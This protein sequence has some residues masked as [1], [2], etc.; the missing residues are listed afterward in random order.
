MTNEQLAILIR[1]YA[2]RLDEH[3][4][5]L[6]DELPESNERHLKWVRK[7]E[8]PAHPASTVVIFASISGASDELEQK[9]IGDFIC[10]DGLHQFS[11]EL[12][13]QVDELSAAKQLATLKAQRAK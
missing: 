11:A 9:P 10:L 12:W 5:K 4:K 2:L 7:D 13:T 1:G 8:K 6:E 3:I